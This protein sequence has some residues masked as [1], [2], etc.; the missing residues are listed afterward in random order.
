MLMDVKKYLERI[1]IDFIPEPTADNLALIQK[2][3]L[4]NVPYET[5]DI[6][7]RNIVPS[8]SL[9]DIYQKIVLQKRGGYCFELNGALAWLLRNLGYHVKESF[10]RWHFSEENPVPPP[11]HRVIQV[12]LENETYIVDAGVGRP[13]ALTPLLLRFNVEQERNGMIFRVKADPVLGYAVQI[14]TPEGFHNFYSFQD[15]IDMPQDFIYVNYYLAT[16]P[17]S[18]FRKK[19]MVNLPAHDGRRSIYLEDGV[20]V[21]RADG[22]Q[23]YIQTDNIARLKEI[24]EENFNI[25]W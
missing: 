21:F 13:T 18:I 4:Q 16:H 8:M 14:Q 2:A 25:I 22:R 3:H 10:G 9:E 17:D 23:E 11:R 1:G 24:L 6:S 20:Y 15:K 12:Y 7:L 19:L 5:C